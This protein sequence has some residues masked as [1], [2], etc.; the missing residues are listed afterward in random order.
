MVSACCW[1]RRLCFGRGRD[2]GFVLYIFLFFRVLG[3]WLCVCLYTRVHAHKLLGYLMWAQVWDGHLEGK[4]NP[5]RLKRSIHV[6]RIGVHSTFVY[7][8]AVLRVLMIWVNCFFLLTCLFFLEKYKMWRQLA[9]HSLSLL[10]AQKTVPW[11][12][13]THAHAFAHMHARGGVG[14]RSKEWSQC[15]CEAHTLAVGLGLDDRTRAWEK[16]YDRVREYVHVSMREREHSHQSV[17]CVY[18]NQH[19]HAHGVPSTLLLLLLR[20]LLNKHS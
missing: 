7:I 10:W 6:D 2:R 16:D 4:K 20:L 9:N 1:R 17:L 15:A 14:K 12:F 5:D 13:Q 3:W 18:T 11:D 19:T 8:Y